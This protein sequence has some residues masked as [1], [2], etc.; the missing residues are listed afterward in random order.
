[1]ALALAEAGHRTLLVDA[2]LRVPTQH[3][4]YACGDVVGLSG[5]VAGRAPV[6]RCIH[7][8][9]IKG[10]DLLPC[11]QVPF[12]PSETINNQAFADLLAQLAVRYDYLVI[13][14]PPVMPVTDARILAA[15]CDLTILVLRAEQTGRRAAADARDGLLGFGANL[16]GVVV[17]DGPRKRNRYGYY[18]GYGLHRQTVPVGAKIGAG[19][20]GNGESVAGET[21]LLIGNTRQ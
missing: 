2:D 7:A 11:G 9:P 3:K 16:L 12:N 8:G 6:E 10:M 19:R 15:M 17:N 1:L 18:G 5:V 21:E 13:D 14:S 20:P 4:I